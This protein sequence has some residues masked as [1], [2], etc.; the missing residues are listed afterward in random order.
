MID[1]QLFRSATHSITI[2]YP[3]LSIFAVSLAFALAC[4]SGA[5][6]TQDAIRWVLVGFATSVSLFGIAFVAL[7]A[8]FRPQL[9]RSEQ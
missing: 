4:L 3:G 6:V 7:A 5:I 1:P 2:R 8:V 9:L